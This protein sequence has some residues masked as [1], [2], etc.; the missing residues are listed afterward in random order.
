MNKRGEEGFRRFA[1]EFDILLQVRVKLSNI[2]V[3]IA[4]I[5]R[6]VELDRADQTRTRVFGLPS[7]ASNPFK[8]STAVK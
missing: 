5:A 7:V 1:R 4:V 6:G 2:K 8:S 3:C